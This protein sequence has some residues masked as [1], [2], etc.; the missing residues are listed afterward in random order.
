MCIGN[1]HGYRSHHVR[2]VSARC[3]APGILLRGRPYGRSALGSAREIF[4]T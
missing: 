3:C 2:S 4:R 1:R